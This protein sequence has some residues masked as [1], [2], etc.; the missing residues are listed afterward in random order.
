[1]QWVKTEG[2]MT[3]TGK[4]TSENQSVARAMA[5]LNLLS[6]SS[7]PLGVREIARQLDVAPSIAQRLVRTLTNA[8]YLEQTGEASRYTIGYRAFQVGNA[9]VGQNSIHSAVMPELYALADQ[10]INGFLGVLRDRA[11]VYLATVQ[12]SGPIALTHRPGS[13]T[14]LHSTALGKAI[15]AEMPD[16][17]VR[18][19]LEE[20]SLPRLTNRTKISIPQLLAELKEVREQG[21]ATNDEENRYGVYSAGA[22]VRDSENRAIGALSGGVPSSGLTRKERSRVIRLVVEAARNASRRLGARID[23]DTLPARKTVPISR[24][25]TTNKPASSKPAGK[26]TPNRKRRAARPVGA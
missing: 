21:Y 16:S 8:G 20:A 13:Q 9:F 17:Q 6:S 25:A 11:V 15:L 3:R 4:P 7:S 22:I 24:R 14:Y 2:F 10:H 23:D 1:M 19:L 12:S 26:T 18:S 5:V